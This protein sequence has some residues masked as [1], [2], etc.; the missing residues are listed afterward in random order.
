MPGCFVPQGFLIFKREKAPIYTGYLPCRTD[1]DSL[2]HRIKSSATSRQRRLLSA[3][4]RGVS[5]AIFS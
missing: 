3:R 5:R 2:F 4:Y 1:T